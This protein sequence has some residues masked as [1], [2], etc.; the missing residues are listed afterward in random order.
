MLE[1][2]NNLKEI[3]ERC[4]HGESLDPAI[5]RWLAERLDRFLDHECTSVDDALGLRQQRGGIPWWLIEAMYERDAALRDLAHMVAG[6]RSLSAQAREVRRLT[7]RY[8]A[9]AWHHDRDR[10]AMPA[11]YWNTARQHV[12]KAFRS[13]APIPLGERR[14]RNI[15]GG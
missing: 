13:G 7:V 6:D 8:A 2:I 12:W 11:A 10:E 14:L 15:L 4:H 3:R 1:V 9:S 5:S